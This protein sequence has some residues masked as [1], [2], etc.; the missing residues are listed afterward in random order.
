MFADKSIFRGNI[1]PLSQVNPVRIFNTNFIHLK[2]EMPI[3]IFLFLLFKMRVSAY[4]FQHGWKVWPDS[5]YPK[6]DNL[7]P[8]VNRLIRLNESYIWI[9]LNKNVF[10]VINFIILFCFKMDYQLQTSFSSLCSWHWN[11]ETFCIWKWIEI[12]FLHSR[13]SG[14]PRTESRKELK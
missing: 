7:S 3:N 8:I 2:S 5:K 9:W 4:R 13:L 6:F 14:I 11:V 1:K 12:N 10:D